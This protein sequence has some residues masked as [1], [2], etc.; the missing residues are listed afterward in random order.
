MKKTKPKKLVIR[1]GIRAGRIAT[2]HNQK[3]VKRG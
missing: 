3:R 2:N 1:S